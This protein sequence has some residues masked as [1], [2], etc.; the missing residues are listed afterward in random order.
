MEQLIQLLETIKCDVNYLEVEDLV[1]GG[2]FDSFAILQ[3]ITEVEEVFDI[4]ITPDEMTTTNFNSAKA[5]W[6]MINRLKQ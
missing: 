4:S 6:D 5:I 3:T 1:D 2:V